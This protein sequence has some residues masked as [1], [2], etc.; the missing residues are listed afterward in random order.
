LQNFPA[1]NRTDALLAADFEL[2]LREFVD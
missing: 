2:R 1:D